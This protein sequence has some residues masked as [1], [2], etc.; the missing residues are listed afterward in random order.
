MEAFVIYLLKS[1]GVLVL[2]YTCYHLFLRKETF[3]DSNR[4][5][6][7]SGIL[8]S[9]LLPLVY[10]TKTIHV[11]STFVVKN[12]VEQP[13]VLM[14]V[15]EFSV[16]WLPIFFYLYILVSLF[17]VFKL[18]FQ[19]ILV[20]GYI[21]HG[22]RK[23][24]HNIVYVQSSRNT[25]PFSFFKYIIYNPEKH[26]QKDL[27]F[28]LAHEQVHASQKH[29]LDILLMEFLLL[30]H[31]FNPISWLY[32]NAI[33]ENLEFL[34]DTQ[35]GVLKDN[36]KQYQY[37]LL[38]Q[39]IGRHNLSIINPFFNSL[40]K[41]R[42]VM[43]NQIPSQR[44]KAVKILTIIPLL[45]LFFFGFN[46]KTQ[47]QIDNRT[48]HQPQGKSIELVIDKDTTDD[49][50][51]AMKNDLKKDNIDF[52]FNVV[53]NKDQKIIQISIDF[54]AK[55]SGGNKTRS[56]SNFNNNDQPI[57][58]IY[59]SYNQKNNSISMGQHKGIHIDM[60]KD[61]GHSV[62]INSDDVEDQR[63]IE[64][65][66]ENGKETIRIDGKEVSREAYEAL[67]DKDG[68]HKRHVKIRKS[69]KG[70]DGNV[71]I[72][73]DSDDE[74]DVRVIGHGGNGFYFIDT[75]GDEEPVFI[76]DGKI[77]SREDMEKLDPS[78][79]ESINVSK[80][81]KAMEKVGDKG[82]NGVVKITTKKN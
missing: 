70:K 24:I 34:A 78:D 45:A 54:V 55:K 37:L 62:W 60:G 7:I 66:D 17:F 4:W 56:S 38:K 61:G 5:F 80:D 14:L 51:E 40:I 3:F 10:Y 73:S 18:V 8:T 11:D 12:S 32:K 19:V 27:E 39:S 82:K 16:N 69:K 47:Y 29:S 41:K 77:S 64:I 2:F 33:K 72:H 63:T 75:D 49:E 9:L 76:I 79:I 57:D 81:E 1:S 22:K 59:I 30:L 15:N 52:S 42:I 71:F 46:T 20:S 31:W 65:I 35:N 6:L 48:L 25:Q 26:S 50:L 67:K 74:H 21:K 58:P 28:I 23:S 36:K 68:P 53:R 43:I 44:I 13:E